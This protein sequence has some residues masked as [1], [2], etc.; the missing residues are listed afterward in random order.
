MQVRLGLSIV[1]FLALRQAL[2]L[3]DCNLLSSPSVSKEPVKPF[4]KE[5][6]LIAKRI[7]NNWKNSPEKKLANGSH[8]PAFQLNMQ[9][10][11]YIVE[12]A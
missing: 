3:S 2:S 6:P 5:Q 7:K 11:D 1:F 12:K 8:F 4:F 9:F 10:A